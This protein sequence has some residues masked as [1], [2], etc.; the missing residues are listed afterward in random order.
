MPQILTH[1]DKSLMNLIVPNLNTL[2][3]VELVD[4]G[5]SGLLD[6]T[7][8]FMLYLGILNM[9]MNPFRMLL[10]CGLRKVEL[11]KMLAKRPSI[12]L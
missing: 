7:K 11:Y 6:P 4:L 8:I 3:N 10:F 9:K 1:S 2:E 12:V 5:S